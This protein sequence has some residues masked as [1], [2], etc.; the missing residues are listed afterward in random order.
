MKNKEENLLDDV[1]SVKEMK[2][3]YLFVDNG[4]RRGCYKKVFGNDQPDAT[5][6]KWFNKKVV[7]EK[8]VEIGESLAVYD[9]VC[10]KVLLSIITNEISEDKDK[11]SAIK[12]WNALRARVHTTIKLESENI[13]DL[14]NIS[15]DNL[16][17]A[18]KAIM[19]GKNE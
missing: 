12:T 10:D 2:V 15:T 7:K 11:I 18:V 9:T 6:Y 4:N 5:I 14:S 13:I 19:G 3:L 1:F 16:S 8:I 17:E